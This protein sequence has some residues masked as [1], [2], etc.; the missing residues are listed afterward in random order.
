MPKKQVS[1]CIGHFDEVWC[2]DFSPNGNFFAAASKD[3]S[4]SVWNTSSWDLAG[5]LN[6]HFAP[7]TCLAWSDD[8][9]FLASCSADKRVRWWNIGQMKLHKVVRVH[10]SEVTGAVFVSHGGKTCLLT[11]SLDG[12]LVETVRANF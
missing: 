6:G 1:V 7:I 4:I 8:S 9:V 3:C 5:K 12:S 2:G 10:R 11:C